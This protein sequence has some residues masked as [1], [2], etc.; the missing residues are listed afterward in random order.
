MRLEIIGFEAK[1]RQLSKYELVLQ[2][3]RD[4]KTQTRQHISYDGPPHA[5]WV[6]GNIHR[7]A[8][9]RVNTTHDNYQLGRPPARLV[10]PRKR[11]PLRGLARE[12]V[13]GPR[14]RVGRRQT[15][16]V[17]LPHVT[18]RRQARLDAR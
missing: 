9:S 18:G 5:S 11:R 16:D 13:D 12:R 15:D 10:G 1:V 6:R 14:E 3:C 7:T 4:K 17:G 8:G 2:T